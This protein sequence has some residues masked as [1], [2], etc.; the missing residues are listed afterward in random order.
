MFEVS[1]ELGAWG[2]VSGRVFSFGLCE[3]SS[4]GSPEKFNKLLSIDRGAPFLR[5]MKSIHF[6]QA[7]ACR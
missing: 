3:E 7:A 4:I 1:L 5:A 2:L 6:S